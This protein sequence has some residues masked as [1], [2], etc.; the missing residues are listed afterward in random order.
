MNVVEV[1]NRI[2]DLANERGLSPYELAKRSNMALSS[3][4]NMFQRG[5]MPKIDTLE[6]LCNGMNITLSDFFASFSKPQAGGYMSEGDTALVETNRRLSEPNQKH[7][8]A[9]A[10]GMLKAQDNEKK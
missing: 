1:H 5:T 9:Y 10:Q 4:Y 3:L 2:N 7:L 8:L 6:K